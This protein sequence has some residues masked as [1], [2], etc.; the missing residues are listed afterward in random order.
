MR[1]FWPEMNCDLKRSLQG[2]PV[3]VKIWKAQRDAVAEHFV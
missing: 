3:M 2:F 1:L